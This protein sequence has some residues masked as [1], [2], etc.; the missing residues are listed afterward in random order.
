MEQSTGIQEDSSRKEDIQEDKMD[1]VVD[2][3]KVEKYFIN[4]P[5]FLHKLHN[6]FLYCSDNEGDQI[7]Y[8][9]VVEGVYSSDSLVVKSDFPS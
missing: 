8:S 6:M 1:P 2:E 3:Y 7:K 9:L 4:F 5:F